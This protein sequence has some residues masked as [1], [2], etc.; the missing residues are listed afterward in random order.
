MNLSLDAISRIIALGR[1]ILEQHGSE[2]ADIIRSVSSTNPPPPVPVTPPAP[3]TSLPEGFDEKFYLA[4]YPDVANAVRLGYYTSGGDHYIK[5]G[6]KEGRVF[7]PTIVVSTLPP[8]PPPVSTPWMPHQTYSSRDALVADLRQHGSSTMVH[9]DGARVWEGD[10]FGPALNYY[11]LRNGS[12][13]QTKPTE[14]TP[15]TPPPP[16]ADG[17][18]IDLNP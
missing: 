12:V 4:M 3:A 5:D 10:G 15:V 13:S 17:E 11:M 2:I 6:Y 9:V 18:I 1:R 7:K 8:T 14:D 16:P